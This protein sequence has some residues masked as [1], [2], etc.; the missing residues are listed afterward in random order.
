MIIS[1][2][3]TIEWFSKEKMDCKACL[4][5]KPML[6]VFCVS[7][8]LFIFVIILFI[9]TQVNA[10]PFTPPVSLLRCER[11]LTVEGPLRQNKTLSA[12][13]CD[14]VIQNSSWEALPQWAMCTVSCL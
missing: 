11:S 14:R 1:P 8:C 12:S 7:W 9:T 4:D 13:Y 6:L 10:L 5:S 2:Q 3:S